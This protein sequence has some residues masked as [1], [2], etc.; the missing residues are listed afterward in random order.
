MGTLLYIRLIGFTAGTLLMLF[1]MVVILGYRRQRNFERV[2]FFLCLAMFLFYSGSL[3]ALN[4]QIYY[5]QPP[6]LLTTFAWTVLYAG[7]CFA[8]AFL[9][10]LHLEYASTRGLII[11]SK[12]D[13]DQWK[14]LMLTFVYA[15]VL[16]SAIRAY[17]TLVSGQS[18]DFLH[19]ANS[20]G[21]LFGMFLGAL[22]GGSAG[23]QFRFAKATM[24]KEERRFHLLAGFGLSLSVLLV[25]FLHILNLHLT[26]L[27]VAVGTSLLEFFPIPLFAVL[28]YAVQKY[29]FLQIGRQTNLMYAISVTFLALLYLGLVRR[30]SVLLEP[31][32]PPEATASILLFVLVVFVE[33]IQRLLG[34]RLH[35]TAQHEMDD[36]RRL[37]FRIREKAREGDFRGFIRFVGDRVKQQFEFEEAWL[38]VLK[39]ILKETIR[40]NS[41]R[42]GAEGFSVYQPGLLN[43]VLCVRPHGA[44]LSGEVR[45]ALELLCEQLPA[46]IDL[47]RL[48][49]DKLRLER[50]LAERERM[51]ALGQ[52]AASISHNLKNPL[53]SIKTILQVQME[54][55]EMPESLKAETRMVLGEISRLSNK[56]GQLLQFSRPAVLGE[57]NAT[58]AVDDV[59]TEICEVM[60]PEAEGKGIKLTA[61]AESG[62][63]V[64][65][66]REAVSDILS[67]LVVNGLEA[68]CC[69]GKVR[70]S[71]VAINGNALICAQDDGKGIPSE[72]REKVMQP[73]FT[74]KTQGTGLGLAIVMRRVTEAGGKIQLESPVA[75]GRGTKFS[76]WLPLRESN[77]AK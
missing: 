42:A 56:L 71:A 77:T 4:A 44:M 32:L 34:K 61:S 18:F 26:P 50:E 52:M 43:A 6:P 5:P 60:R 1:W 38:E 73:F 54:S 57:G 46:S 36:V 76:V 59:V 13:P 53:G 3:L 45:A 67:N 9:V 70:V 39:P 69:G 14:R 11:I 72:L 66:S 29:N 40:D 12:G 2:F 68:S 30:V 10:H 58:F 37:I 64:K 7:L 15:G 23:W 20:M 31:I 47:C 19:P 62:L 17:A 41:Q 33:P 22:L 25:A 55:A 16:L 8:P 21:R 65:A 63:R 24:H 49:E 51:A 28:I 75:D 27:I 74:T 35:E 48:I